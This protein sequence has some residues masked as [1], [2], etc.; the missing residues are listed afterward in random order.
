MNGSEFDLLIFAWIGWVYDKVEDSYGRV[1]A[2]L[3]AFV[4]GLMLVGLL[5]WVLIVLS[6][7]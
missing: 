2:W 3:V 7:W 5:V 6:R 4:A 1:A